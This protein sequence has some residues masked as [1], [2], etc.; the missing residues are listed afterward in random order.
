VCA[1]MEKV[2]GGV[3]QTRPLTVEQ[4]IKRTIIE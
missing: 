1:L 4:A 3:E 2:C